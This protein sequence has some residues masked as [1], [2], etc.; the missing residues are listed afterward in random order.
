MIKSVIPFMAGTAVG[1]GIWAYTQ[2]KK[3]VKKMV[4]KMVDETEN[5]MKQIKDLAKSK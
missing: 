2:N 3:D 1:L 4:K 5:M